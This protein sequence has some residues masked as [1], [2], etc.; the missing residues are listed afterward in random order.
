MSMQ[1]EL[2]SL[3][4][5]LQHTNQGNL[6]R[7]LVDGQFSDAYFNLLMRIVKNCTEGQF[8]EMYNKGDFPKIKMNS[9]DTAIK[10]SFWGAAKKTFQ[11][12]GLIGTAEAAPKAA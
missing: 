9:N 3:Y 5:F 8:I 6:K 11:F 1:D 10:D 2:V 12:R 7:I 4:G